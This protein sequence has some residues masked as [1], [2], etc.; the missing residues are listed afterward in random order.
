MPRAG[1]KWS[2]RLSRAA[3][4]DFGVQV[5]AG[6]R[7][8]GWHFLAAAVAM[9]LVGLGALLAGGHDHLVLTGALWLGAILLVIATFSDETSVDK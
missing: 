5:P 3:S 9:A 8:K 2:K 6:T 4:K 7:L 1:N